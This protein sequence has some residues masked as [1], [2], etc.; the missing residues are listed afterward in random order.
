MGSFF[1]QKKLPS[2]AN[3]EFFGKKLYL[4]QMRRILKEKKVGSSW[5]QTRVLKS[6]DHRSTHYSIPSFSGQWPQTSVYISITQFIFLN[7]RKKHKIKF[8]RNIN[9][10]NWVKFGHPVTSNFVKNSQKRKKNLLL[11]NCGGQRSSRNC[12][13][14]WHF[15]KNWNLCQIWK[16]LSKCGGIPEGNSRWEATVWGL[17]LCP[18]LSSNPYFIIRQTFNH[19]T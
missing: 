7:E 18:S 4:P 16:K 17:Q 19:L 11:R 1:W 13:V 12:S 2:S 10:I 9:A 6:I 8:V 5:T 3:A 15:E 14:F